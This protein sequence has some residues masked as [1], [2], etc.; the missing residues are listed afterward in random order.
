[1]ERRGRRSFEGLIN[2]KTVEDIIDQSQN[3]WL[4]KRKEEIVRV[5]GGALSQVDMFILGQ[6]MDTVKCLDQVIGGLDDMIRGLVNE[7]ELKLLITVPGV[8]E[9]A[10][11]VI[12]AEIGDVERFKSGKSLA[13]WA[14][15]V[16]SV[17]ESAGK[18]LTGG[19]TK[20][21]SKWLRRIMVQVAHAAKRVKNSQLREFYLR[22]K[23]R[24]G[25]KTAVV[26][27]ARKI[28]T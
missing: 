6:C 9:R 27:L 12:L 2:G 10:A 25:E 1:M 26:A 13:S 8:D 11:A 5:V 7:D 17:H 21:G 24:K 4:K 16:P 28:L 19:I 23:A 15:L 22:V 20:R 18:N 3:K 14:G